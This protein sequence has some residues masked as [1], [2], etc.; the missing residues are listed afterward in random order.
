MSVFPKLYPSSPCELFD[1]FM[2]IFMYLLKK[3]KAF[4]FTLAGALTNLIVH[5]FI[6]YTKYMLQRRRF[7]KYFRY[8]GYYSII[9]TIIKAILFVL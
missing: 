8:T 5:W 6:S 1:L 4:P 2:G 9:G 3:K 7:L